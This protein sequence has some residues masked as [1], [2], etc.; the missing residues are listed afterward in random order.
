MEILGHLQY[1]QQTYSRPHS[2]TPQSWRYCLT[3][4]PCRC[5]E[6]FQYSCHTSYHRPASPNYQLQERKRR[7]SHWCDVSII[8]LSKAELALHVSSRQRRS[9]PSAHRLHLRLYFW[10]DFGSSGLFAGISAW[11]SCVCRLWFAC[12]LWTCADVAFVTD[13]LEIV[14]VSDV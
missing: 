3:S 1:A 10:N 9:W 5:H 6:L 14:D 8:L 11:V 7:S 13:T 4:C 2:S 12:H